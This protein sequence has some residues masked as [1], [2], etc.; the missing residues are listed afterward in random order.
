MKNTW[1]RIVQV[2][3]T[4]GLMAILARSVDWAELSVVIQHMNW[5]TLWLAVLIWLGSHI[6]NVIR[7]RI[8]L[9]GPP[10]G[11]SRLLAY[12]GAGLFANN[13][14]PTGIGGDG[15]RVALLSRD[16]GWLRA[17]VSVGADRAIGLASFS[18]L[19]L[20][21]IG[22]GLPS[23]LT[24]E[25]VVDTPQHSVV[26]VSV[27]SVLSIGVIVGVLATRSRWQSRIL[28]GWS[29]WRVYQRNRSPGQWLWLLFVT[30]GLSVVSNLLLAAAQWA[31]MRAATVEVP[32]GAALWA[33]ILVALSLLLPI[34]VNGL[35]VMEGVFVIVLSRYQIPLTTA[36]AVAILIRVVSIGFSLLGGLVSLRWRPNSSEEPVA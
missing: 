20:I 4:I 32:F 10:A 29:R 11:Y 35:G 6:G 36:V 21:G 28:D 15:V 31:I 23:N 13:F 18:A 30:Y 24:L 16:A 17:I 7:W 22:L 9:P 12:Y 8:I 27:V 25:P 5:P 14:L 19:I 34:A 26:V 3:V 1:L 33:A 2:L